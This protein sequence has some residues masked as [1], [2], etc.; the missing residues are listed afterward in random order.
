M[1]VS[2]KKLRWIYAPESAAHADGKPIAVEAENADPIAKVV[3]NAAKA[4]TAPLIIV[5]GFTPVDAKKPVQITDAT[6]KRLQLAAQVAGEVR[7]I[8]L[9]VTGGNV[10]PDDTPYNEAWEMR[11]HLRDSLKVPFPVILDPY[12]RHSTTNLRNA[13]RFLVTRDIQRAIVVTDGGQGFYFGAQWISTFAIRCK[14]ELGYVVGSLQPLGL[15]F[16]RINFKP[17]PEVMRLG[18][19]PLDP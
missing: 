12:A 16:K 6:I 2:M 13:G 11:R 3:A 19:D 8:G 1:P 5:P 4:P 17:F 9:L 14:E 10:H 7:A 15:G 18:A